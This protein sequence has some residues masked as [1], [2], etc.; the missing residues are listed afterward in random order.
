MASAVKYAALAVALHLMLTGSMLGILSVL[1]VASVPPSREKGFPTEGLHNKKAP[2]PENKDASDSE[3]DSEGDDDDGDAFSDGEAG[4]DDYLSGG[5][6]GEDDDDDPRNAHHANG[7]GGSDDEDD[8]DDEE[9]E[10]D[11]SDDDEE[12]EEDEEDIPPAKK[13]NQRERICC[14]TTIRQ[15]ILCIRNCVTRR[16]SGFGRNATSAMV[17]QI[18]GRQVS[19]IH[20]S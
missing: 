14:S 6:G 15:T 8:D 2:G 20:L 16:I 3:D 5:E 18:Y 19:S 9:D 10:D 11:D 7:K 13:R 1:A 17:G 12:D 4:E